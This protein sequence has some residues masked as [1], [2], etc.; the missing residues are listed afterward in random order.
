MP[1]L[2]E[3]TKSFLA[4]KCIAVVGV[5]RNKTQ[6]KAANLIYRK[7]RTEFYRVYAVNP[8]AA[9]VEGD[10]CYRSLKAIPD[11]PEAVIIVTRPEIAAHIVKDCFELGI[12]NVWLHRGPDA[13]TSS[14]SP[15]A[16][17]YCRKHGITVIP[18]GC[19]MMFINNADIPHRFMRWLQNITG[20]LPKQV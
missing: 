3:A 15:E 17:D 7:L 2:K 18:G 4:H 16:V 14:V 6:Y 5:S 9:M 12:N 20:K 13:K 11:K 19:P 1:A 10:T 8:H